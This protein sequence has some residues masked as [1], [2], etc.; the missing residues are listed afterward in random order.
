M[1]DLDKKYTPLSSRES[2]NIIYSAVLHS[3]V[4]YLLIK[5]SSL[6][7]RGTSIVL[8]EILVQTNENTYDDTT[9]I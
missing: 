1:S 6:G 3:N 5:L 9:K 2:N 4:L 8:L 7:S